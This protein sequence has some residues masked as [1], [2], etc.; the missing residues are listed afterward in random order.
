MLG[1]A[2][3]LAVVL[4]VGCDA[5]RSRHPA[6]G[7]LLDPPSLV[8]L[9]KPAAAGV[10][11]TGKVTLLNFWGTWCP[12]CRR[13]LPGLARLAGRL[14]AEPRFQL[15]AISCGPG[16][17]DSPAAL[18]AETRGFLAGQRIA[19]DA[20]VFS[21]PLAHAVFASRLSL[22]AFPSTFLVAPDGRVRR[23]WVGYRPGDEAT[24]A[25]AV[26]ALLQEGAAVEEPTP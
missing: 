24:M 17:E 11:F 18:A 26:L 19:I 12:P 23:V 25:A 15:V 16:T 2:V 13:E 4:G 14:A 9:A 7:L 20:W 8:S 5:G 1:A 21:D 22:E 3:G 6:V 10:E